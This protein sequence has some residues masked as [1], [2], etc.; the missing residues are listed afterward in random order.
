L[1]PLQSRQI[2]IRERQ[3]RMRLMETYQD[4]RREIDALGRAERRGAGLGAPRF[5][6]GAR[7]Q[8]LMM[9]QGR[10]LEGLRLRQGM[11][12]ERLGG[13]PGPHRRR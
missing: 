12:R 8:G 6:W 4:Q 13:S 1:A 3:E 5:G 11:E 9:R 10:E 2:E 7:M